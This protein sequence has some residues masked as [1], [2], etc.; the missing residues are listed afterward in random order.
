[1]DAFAKYCPHGAKSLDTPHILLDIKAL[2]AYTIS[3]DI[4]RKRP[5]HIWEMARVSQGLYLLY[6]RYPSTVEMRNTQGIL[7]EL[8]LL[9]NKVA[10]NANSKYS[11]SM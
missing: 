3:R 11:H 1:M 9:Y 4:H 6:E 8:I 5:L 2:V 7:L 10:D